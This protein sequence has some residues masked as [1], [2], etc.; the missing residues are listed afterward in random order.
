MGAER[1][2]RLIRPQRVDGI[3]LARDQAGADIAAGCRHPVALPR[4]V[5]PRVVAE[6]G[7]CR[8]MLPEPC[9]C[10]LLGDVPVLVEAAVHLCHRLQSVAPVDEE[11]GPLGQHDR[12]AGR[13]GEA[14]EPRQPL[15]APRHV[16]AL[17]LVAE[18]H[19]E[20]IEAA[21]DKLGPE[22]RKP[23]LLLWG[24]YPVGS[25]GVGPPQRIEALGEGRVGVGLRVDQA[26]PV[27]VLYCRG[28]DAAHQRFNVL[29]RPLDTG[30]GERADQPVGCRSCLGHD[31]VSASTPLT[32]SMSA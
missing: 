2:R 15:R 7:A 11:C 27:P 28:G 10:R 19:D 26:E 22:R 24:V 12:H 21:P 1:G 30:L 13:A 29:D 5:Q 31:R 20:A 6:R 4:A 18:R 8:E 3:V 9:V 17:M 23:G 25:L 16:L 14:G 32:A